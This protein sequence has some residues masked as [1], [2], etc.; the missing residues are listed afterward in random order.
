M[1]KENF[2]EYLKEVANLYKISYEELKT[3][4][5]EYPYCQNLHHLLVE[6]SKLDDNEHLEENLQKA[7]TYSND[8]SHLFFKLKQLAQPE[9][10]EESVLAREEYLELPDLRNPGRELPQL[11][12][13][14]QAE[15][16][17]SPIALT[18]IHEEEESPARDNTS[19]TEAPAS[20]AFPTG[21]K[22]E[23]TKRDDFPARGEPVPAPP[24]S[25]APAPPVAPFELETI[26]AVATAIR[27][28]DTTFFRPR[29]LKQGHSLLQKRPHRQIR[30]RKEEGPR[31]KTSFPSWVQ[32]FQP[33]HVKL[34]LSELMEA[35]KHED[36][37]SGKK[38][39][40]SDPVIEQVIAQS[41]RENSE[42]ASE[43]LAELLTAQMQYEKA[44]QV[45][46][47]LI[48][49]FPEKSAF[50]AEKI[51]NLKKLMI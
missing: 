25:P 13:H 18:F 39:A 24:S 3:L 26:D 6:K 5:V 40:K 20:G 46:E 43:T 38:K 1:N 50:F 9:M 45:Y 16:A 2:T 31:P 14:Q 22:Q 10:L 32:Q 7:A 28:L 48:L 29:L 4:V 27:V 36:N 30:E 23:E 19:H 21:N 12:E 47:R 51:S 35:K 17:P 33:S 11:I 34:K 42:L 15:E 8:R 44:I 49:K 37:K 41:V